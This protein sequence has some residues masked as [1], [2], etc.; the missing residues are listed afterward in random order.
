MAKPTGFMDHTREMPRRRPIEERVHDNDEVYLPFEEQKAQ[1]QAARCMDCGVP[2]CQAG[3]PLGNVI[4]DWN[5]LAWRGDWHGAYERLRATNNFPEF[6]GRLCPAPCESACVLGIIDKPVTIER[7]EQAIADRA[8]A[9]GWL[10]PREPVRQTGKRVAVV[11]SGPAG[12]ACADQLN[13]AGHQVT[14]FERDDRI[15]GLLRYG[16]PDFKMDKTVLDRRLAVMEAEGVVFQPNTEVGTDLSIDDLL[17]F[18]AVVLCNGST[19]PRALDLPGRDLDGIHYAMEYLTQHNR[20]VAGDDLS[21][22]A[23]ID[24]AGKHVLVIGGGDTASDCIGTAHRQG[25]A[26]VTNFHIWPAPPEER[27]EQMP[28]PFDPHLFQVSTSHE[29]GGDRVWAV[30]TV[31]FEGANGHV[32]AVQ[33]VD[34][35]VGPIGEN[36][37]PQALPVPDSERRWKADLVLI[38]IGYTGPEGGLMGQLGVDCTPRGSVA[39]DGTYQTS[40][41]GVFAAG[42]ARR[43]QS[44]VVWA[45]SE[46]REAARAVDQYLTGF[47]ALPTKGAGDLPRVR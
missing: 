22:E 41:P 23:L 34:I 37:R 35:A 19:K 1:Q 21:G 26:S 46:G 15:G 31:Q 4:P 43:G 38:A 6:T 33:T 9:E 29:E 2:F 10:Q 13:Q 24:A 11:G 30:Q 32:R 39:T 14:V 40:I 7:I 18:D 36:G 28:W 12:L 27:T 45:I 25:A 16:I 20:R 42:D 5:D 47:I 3:C 44:L 8:V 17:A